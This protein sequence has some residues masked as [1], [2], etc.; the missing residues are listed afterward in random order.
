MFQESALF[1]WLTAGQNIALAL[2]LAGVPRAR[3]SARVDGAAGSGAAARA[4]RTA[5]CTSC[6][7]VSGSG[8][9]WPARWPRTVSVLLM[10]EPFAALDA[11]TRDVLHDELTRV[12]KRDREQS[13]SS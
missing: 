9:R 4:S 1:P 8:S 7:A 10:D 5:G 13:W 6:P 12:W 3:R 2:K 11:I